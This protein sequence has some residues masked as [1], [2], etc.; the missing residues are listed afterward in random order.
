MHPQVLA[1]LH[2]CLHPGRLQFAGERDRQH[3]WHIGVHILAGAP[4]ICEPPLGAEGNLALRRSLFDLPERL[5]NAGDR[6]VQGQTEPMPA[7]E[8]LGSAWLAHAATLRSRPIEKSTTGVSSR[9]IAD[10]FTAIPRLTRGNGETTGYAERVREDY[11]CRL[12]LSG[13]P[14]RVSDGWPPHQRPRPR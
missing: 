6:A 14:A 10:S 3:R 9:R 1:H 2:D 11:A 4:H 8:L 5:D 13:R 7:E 12:E